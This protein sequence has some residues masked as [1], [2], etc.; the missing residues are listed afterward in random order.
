MHFN[1]A[2]LRIHRSLYTYDI[3]MIIN[4]VITLCTT[5]LYLLVHQVSI[6][7]KVNT[8]WAQS[9]RLLRGTVDGSE[10][11]KISPFIHRSCIKNYLV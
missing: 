11:A 9:L 5:V 2:N 8:E 10:Q 1:S 7:H 3:G 6:N 4:E